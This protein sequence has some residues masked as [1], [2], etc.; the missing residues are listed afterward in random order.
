MTER[1]TIHAIGKE[2]RNNVT[3][4]ITSQSQCDEV[5]T[6]NH[7]VLT[8]EGFLVLLHEATADVDRLCGECLKALRG[9]REPEYQRQ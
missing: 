3:A 1:Q 9:Q 6:K 8:A 5:V 2:F 4:Q 7:P